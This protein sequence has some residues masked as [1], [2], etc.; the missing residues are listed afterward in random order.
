MLSEPT[1]HAV[2]ISTFTTSTRLLA[3]LQAHGAPSQKITETLGSIREMTGAAV[4]FWFNQR[5]GEVIQSPASPPDAE[6]ACR[7]F[8][9]RLLAESDTSKGG[10]LSKDLTGKRR[11]ADLPAHSA[12]AACVTPSKGFWIVAVSPTADQPFAEPELKMI[13]LAGAMLRKQL[14]YD[15]RMED[16]R[17]S[18]FELVRCLATVVDAKDSCTAGH[19]D[20]VSQIAARLGR[21]LGLSSKEVNDLRVAGLLHDVGKIGIRDD[22]LTKPEKLTAEEFE[23]IQQHPVIGDRIVSTI[24]Y[25]AHLRPGVRNHHERYDGRG[26]PDQLAG[27]DIPLMARILAVA[28]SVDAMMSP[29]C[30]RKALTPPQI[31]QILHKFSGTQWDPCIVESFMSCRHEIYPPIYQKGVND[32]T[33]H[34]IDE[35][36]IAMKDDSS[37]T[38]SSLCR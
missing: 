25:L 27:E 5:T 4:V 38:F 12:V 36:V 21:K 8:A 32:S 28:D 7:N 10:I 2:L 34:A 24:R 17:S 3:L 9:R 30:Y 20:R 18:I 15:T 31:D 16:V 23:H 26:Y 11:I 33:Q 22:I 1:G 19:S 13:A 14:H 29:R 6:E 35:I 37:L